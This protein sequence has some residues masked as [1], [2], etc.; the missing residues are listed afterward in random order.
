[1]EL[2]QKLKTLR[3][4][5]GLTQEELALRLNVSRSA[6]AKWEQG[7]GWPSLDML[8]SLAL[9]FHTSIDDLLGEQGVQ[10]FEHRQKKRFWIVASTAIVSLSLTMVSTTLL[11]IELK[12]AQ[13]PTLVSEVIRLDAV[14]L[15]ED[16]YEVAYTD[17]D[18]NKT[19]SFDKSAV[20]FRDLDDWSIALSP[21]DYLAIERY[22]DE[23]RQA[24]LLDNAQSDAIKGYDLVFETPSEDYRY[25]YHEYMAG[26]DDYPY[27]TMASDIPHLEEAS[28]H[29][30]NRSIAGQ[31]Y[32]LNAVSHTIY[33][34][35]DLSADTLMHFALKPLSMDGVDREPIDSSWFGGLN[36]IQ[37]LNTKFKGYLNSYA[38]EGETYSLRDLVSFDVTVAFVASID[39]LTVRQYDEADLLIGEVDIIDQADIDAFA[40][41]E[42]AA[43][44]KYYVDGSTR[45][46]TLETGE[47]ETFYIENGTPLV[48]V[49]E[50]SIDVDD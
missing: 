2:N 41:D 45:G 44:L 50:L 27:L 30:S 10:L 32:F 39:Q 24:V 28:T 47:S 49:F 20:S 31:T 42:A 46:R 22:G 21:N 3:E 34:D 19:L 14:T 37:S 23:V 8:K 12:R 4:A 35:S 38:Y 36:M 48:T 25:Y 40:I 15:T 13:T 5:M 29:I 9:F 18:D 43:Y 6:I 26:L 33:A 16:R 11:I 7:Q 17:E 1:M